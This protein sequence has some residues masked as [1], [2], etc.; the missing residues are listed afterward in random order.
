MEYAEYRELNTP[1]LRLRRISMADLKDYFRLFGSS[2]ISE[3]M[4][5]E[6]HTHIHQSE[7]AIRKLLERYAD[8]RCY[9]WGIALPE[10]GRLI[11]IIELLRFDEE[12]GTCSFAYMLR[13]D[14]WGMGYGTEALRAAIGFAFSH[15]K[16]DAVIADHMGPNPASGKAMQKAGMTYVRTIPGAYV[17]N[18]SCFD[19]VQ[20]RITR[21]EWGN[22]R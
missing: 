13:E 5:W 11:G 18:G 10:T 3:F 8:G 7:A 2:R 12:S 19:Q 20:Y 21:Q 6:P 22:R 16:M 9:R 15:M 1:R 17:K 4:L 14:F